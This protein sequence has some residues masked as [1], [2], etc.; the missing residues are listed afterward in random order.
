[1]V[2]VVVIAAD[3]RTTGT[4]S[5]PL[6]SSPRQWVDEWTAASLES[7][8]RVCQ[9][10]FAP[11]LAAVFKADTGRSCTGYYTSVNSSSFRIRH[12]LE[13]GPTAT[14]EARE[15]AAHPKWGYFTIVLSHVHGGWRAVDMVPGGSVRPK[16]CLYFRCRRR[17]PRNARRKAAGRGRQ[18][19]AT[20]MPARFRA[21]PL[22][23]RVV[24]CCSS[25]PEMNSAG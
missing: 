6:P 24:T 12:V 25:T 18:P 10:L 15:V 3:Q 1:L 13:D 9:H 11:A 4:P 16:D 19:C 17:E 22:R 23:C 8:A 20:E 5:V 2:G 21:V 7:P 14:V